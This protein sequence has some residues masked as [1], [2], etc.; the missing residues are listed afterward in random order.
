MN[1]LEK[2]FAAARAVEVPLSQEWLD[3]LAQIEQEDRGSAMEPEMPYQHNDNQ[4]QTEQ[5]AQ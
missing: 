3:L 5:V 4:L 2:Y 1:N